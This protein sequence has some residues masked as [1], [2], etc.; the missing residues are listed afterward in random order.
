MLSLALFF[1]C[2]KLCVIQH[3]D[4]TTLMPKSLLMEPYFKKRVDSSKKGIRHMTQMEILVF[5]EYY[6]GKLAARIETGTSLLQMLNSVYKANIGSSHLKLKTADN[7]C[8]CA[9]QRP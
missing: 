5:P 9:T 1:N 6:C 8:M 7:V 3:N 4:L 2:I